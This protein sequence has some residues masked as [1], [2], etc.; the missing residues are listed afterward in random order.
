[1][2]CLFFFEDVD[3]YKKVCRVGIVFFIGIII[4]WYDFYIYGLV[5]VLVFGK[6]FFFVN[7]DLG[8]VILLFFV[9]FWLGFIVCLL[10]GII[11]GY[12][13]DCIGCKIILVII[14]I[15]MGI[16]M[17]CI[18]LLLV[19]M[20]IGIWVLI[21][22]VVLC[23]VQ[24]IVVGGEWGGVILIVSESVFKGKGI[25]YVVFV[26][27][28]LFIGNLLVILVFFVFSVLFVLDFI[29]WGWC[30]LFLFFV[31]LVIVGMVI[32]LKLEELEDM[33]CVLV[34]KCMVKLLFV[35]VLGKYWKIVLF[36]VG[37]LLI[38]YVIYFKSIFVFFW[39]IKIFGYSQGIFFSI[40]V[41]VLVVQFFSQLLGVLFIL[42]IDMC[43]V[44]C[45]MVLLEFILMLVMFFVVEIKVYWI[46][47]VGMCLVMVLYVMFYGVVGGIFV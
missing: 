25:L 35:E 42:C 14:L 39:V 38:I 8:L 27:Q 21:F 45:L 2:L 1:M 16:V 6:V 10:G 13:G 4:E 36:G 24:G 15:M 44:V 20:Q 18:G 12:F 3:L 32:C 40:I 34:Q 37:V 22:L 31:V 41:V 47:V 30:V 29:F 9:I 28:G 17:I 19:Y 23:I 46:V 26:Q 5:V 43:K 7:M 33:K 11:F